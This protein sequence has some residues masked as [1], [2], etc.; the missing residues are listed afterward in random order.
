MGK[1]ELIRRMTPLESLFLALPRRALSPFVDFVATRHADM[2]AIIRGVQTNPLKQLID[3]V[4]HIAA[5]VLAPTTSPICS[6]AAQS[7]NAR[8]SGDSN[9]RDEVTRP[10]VWL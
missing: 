8:A 7:S 1:D 4:D 6:R 2:R 3:T 9:S 10:T 5:K